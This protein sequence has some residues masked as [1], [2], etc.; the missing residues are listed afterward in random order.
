MT[1]APFE[2]VGGAAPGGKSVKFI[3]GAL[4]T[5]PEAASYRMSV[6]EPTAGAASVPFRFREERA[7]TR[8]T[9]KHKVG[10]AIFFVTV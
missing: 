6:F 3:S 5:V 7:L 4:G 1:V 9:A 8:I 2:K 10:I